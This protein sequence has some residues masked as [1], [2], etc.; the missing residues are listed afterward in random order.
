MLGKK[1]IILTLAITALLLALLFGDIAYAWFS[2]KAVANAVDF[3]D[4]VGDD[5]T[6]KA[7]KSGHVNIGLNIDSYLVLEKDGH[8]IVKNVSDLAGKDMSNI[9]LYP[10]D[11]IDLGLVEEGE[12]LLRS[13]ISVS[14]ENKS[15]ADIVARLGSDVFCEKPAV[16]TRQSGENVP[17]I[18]HKE[19]LFK[20]Y[21]LRNEGSISWFK[22]GPN[23]YGGASIQYVDHDGLDEADFVPWDYTDRGF[24]GEAKRI[25][26]LFGQRAEDM[27]E[28]NNVKLTA[29]Q[30]D[31]I[32]M[33]YRQ[34]YTYLYMPEGSQITYSFEFVWDSV[35]EFL[36]N[37]YQYSVFLFDLNVLTGIQGQGDFLEAFAVQPMAEAVDS[38]FANDHNPTRL[39]EYLISKGFPLR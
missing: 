20:V 39:S 18:Y 13:G 27:V 15:G 25:S 17:Y 6:L 31:T 1:F 16:Y 3:G 7:A 19:D 8:E 38:F 22:I 28:Q 9:I 29:E 5:L 4:D 33:T 35:N 21:S 2:D 34:G 10:G 24:Y 30:S 36:D 23:P 37:T 14:L 32:F 12:K 11:I 26:D